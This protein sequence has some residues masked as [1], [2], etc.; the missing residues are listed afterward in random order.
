MKKIGLFFT[1]LL[2]FTVGLLSSCG[3]GDTPATQVADLIEQGAD[4]IKDFTTVTDFSQLKNCLS[5]E[6]LTIIQENSDY[7]LSG[8]DK[9]KLKKSVKKF[10]EAVNEKAFRELPIESMRE[11]GRT[12]IE[13]MNTAIDDNIEKAETLGDLSTVFLKF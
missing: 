6:I 4:N 3:K 11:A 13:I 9:H 10:L 12:Q 2:I 8:G 7:K 1:F 5:P